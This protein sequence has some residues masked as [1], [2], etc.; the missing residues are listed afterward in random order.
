MTNGVRFVDTNVLAYAH[1]ASEPT[2]QAAARAWLRAALDRR[3]S[4]VEHAVLQEFYVVATR[5]F[6]PPISRAVTRW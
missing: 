3:H 4:R 2:K 6:D 5:K 1:D